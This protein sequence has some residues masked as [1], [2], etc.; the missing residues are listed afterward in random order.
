LASMAALIK[1]T[2]V[3]ASRFVMAVALWWVDRRRAWVAVDVGD[4][5]GGKK[6]HPL[7]EGV[8]RR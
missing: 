6:V 8:R 1:A 3:F 4:S 2:G 5:A 7:E